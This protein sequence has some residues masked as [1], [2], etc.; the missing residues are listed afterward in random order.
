MKKIMLLLASLG[1]AL[2]CSYTLAE[3]FR[4]PQEMTSDDREIIN[5]AQ[6]DYYDCVQEKMLEFSNNSDDPR[7][8]SDQVLDVCSVILIKL[9]GD[10]G[11]RNMNPHFTQRYIYNTKNKAAKQLLKNLMMII[12]SRQQAIDPDTAENSGEVTE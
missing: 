8:I 6:A 7:I 3:E 11:E 2:S 10:L 5:E 1:L 9:D 12:A 4:S